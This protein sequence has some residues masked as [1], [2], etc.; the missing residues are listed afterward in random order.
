MAEPRNQLL[1]PLLKD[2]SRSFY[3]TLRV[4]PAKIRPQIGLAYLLARTT[5]TIADTGLLA[6]E[7]RLKALELLR[8]RI[9]GTSEASLDFAELAQHQ[10]LPEE[11]ILLEKCEA[12]LSLLQT[13]TPV[14]LKLVREVLDTI[15]GG[16]ELDL[17]RFGGASANRILALRTAAELE[18]YTYRVAGCVGEFWTR[19][20][21]VHLFPK[22]GLDESYLLSHGI[23]FG[24]GLQLVNILRDISTDLHN[25]R[26]Y[27][28]SDQLAAAGLTPE[29][30]LKPNNE[31]RF[32][33]V[34]DRWLERA[35]GHL[36]AGW[37]YTNALPRGSIRVR[38]ACAW[39]IQIGLETVKLLRFGRVLD[40]Q[41]RLKVTRSELKKLMLRSVLLYPFPAWKRLVRTP[42]VHLSA[43]T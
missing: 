11:R 7:K 40:A 14:D 5:D 20:C 18:D 19:M 10:G 15:T 16:Q 13:L 6:L 23:R 30:L 1:G 12:T 39:P 28:P 25:G 21:L 35:E 41:K 22:A 26:C 17:Q 27:L 34:Y 2:V 37:D 42:P 3:L 43:G 31:S 24:Q 9:Q 29:D 36:L 4:L 33:P 38:L 32:K 8:A